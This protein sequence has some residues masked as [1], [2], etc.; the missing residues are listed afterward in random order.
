VKL[1]AIVCISCAAFGQQV[2]DTSFNP[3]I[4]K[5]A[6]AP[7]KGPV[8]L[9]DEAHF[10]FHTME[11][12][13]G[14]FARLI[15]RDGYAVKPNTA[16]F[17]AASLKEA[18]ILVVANA[19]HEKNRKDWTPPNPSAFTEGEI[20]AVI[21]WVRGGGSLLLIADHMPFAGAASALG[22]ALGFMFHNGY[23]T[24]PVRRRGEPDV[25]RRDSGTLAEHAIT[26]G[27]TPAER[28]DSVATFTGS[29]FQAA[30]A[31][32]M[33]V[34]GPGFVSLTPERPGDMSKIASRAPVDGWLQGGVT[35]LGKGRVAVFGE[36]AMFSAQ[37]AG[38]ERAP[39]GMNHP[40]AAG[41]AQ[42]LLN[43]MHWLTNSL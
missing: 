26:N 9:I 1:A 35:R 23:V 39:M 25:F 18:R 36:A 17:S 29:A 6:F 22:T 37:R 8:V 27:R 21:D 4:E 42:F 5:P 16:P 20:K 38:P 7:G 33:L 28:V 15:A 11:G 2:A 12:R 43:L 41:N 32:A 10:N 13:Y 34:L 14:A 40:R 3:P 19:L 31:E 24:A 30:K